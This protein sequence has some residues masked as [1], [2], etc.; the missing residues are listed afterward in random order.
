MQLEESRSTS[1]NPHENGINVALQCGAGKRNR[2]SDLRITNAL[3]Y[4]LSYSG[5]ILIL[6]HAL[7]RAAVLEAYTAHKNRSS[8]R[9]LCLSS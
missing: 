1:R 7:S 5:E 8:N 3:L 9:R 4:Q 6:K 2:T